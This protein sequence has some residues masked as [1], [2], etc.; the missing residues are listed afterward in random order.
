MAEPDLILGALA[1]SS[2]ISWIQLRIHPLGGLVQKFSKNPGLIVISR[3]ALRSY[4]HADGVVPR[5]LVGISDVG[6]VPH[7]LHVPRNEAARAVQERQH[8]FDA[9]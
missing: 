4:S 1:V 6:I 3:Q 2:R 8:P 9:V 7:E 5:H